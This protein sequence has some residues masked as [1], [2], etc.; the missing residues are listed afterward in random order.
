MLTSKLYFTL[1]THLLPRAFLRGN[2]SMVQVP[3]GVWEYGLR[4]VKGGFFLITM[5]HVVPQSYRRHFFCNAQPKL[6]SCG[7]SS[8][9]VNDVGIDGSVGASCVGKKGYP[10]EVYLISH[11]ICKL[12]KTFFS[13][14]DIIPN[15]QIEYPVLHLSIKGMYL[16]KISHPLTQGI[17]LFHDQINF[18]PSYQ[19]CI[20]QK[21]IYDLNQ[22]TCQPQHVDYVQKPNNQQLVSHEKKVGFH[23]GFHRQ[24]CLG[25]RQT[26][27]DLLRERRQDYLKIGTR[28][29]HLEY[30]DDFS[31]LFHFV[32][33]YPHKMFEIKFH[34]P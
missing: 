29:Q 14:W 31:P 11:I 1:Q 2:F 9:T 5:C 18:T 24:S 25:E 8:M 32:R 6:F 20:L 26:V 4:G 7:T 28:E 30:V 12:F 16:R 33:E 27:S 23:N 21:H 3:E 34:L 15:S 22:Q 10:R 13:I 17:L 19:T